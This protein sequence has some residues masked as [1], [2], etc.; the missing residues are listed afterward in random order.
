MITVKT[1][2]KLGLK[3][4]FPDFNTIVAPELYTISYAHEMEEPTEAGISVAERPCGFILQCK[5]DDLCSVFSNYNGKLT[6]FGS[7]HHAE[8]AECVLCDCHLMEL[9]FTEP[10]DLSTETV[11]N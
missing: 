3:D 1:Y 10:R 8:T 9:Y 6:Y 4:F 11:D 2:P 7:F 5:T